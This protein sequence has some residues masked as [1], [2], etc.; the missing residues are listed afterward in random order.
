MSSPDSLDPSRSPIPNIALVLRAGAAGGVVDLVYATGRGLADSGSVT[1]PWRGVASG[2]LGGK[3]YDGNLSPV[4]LGLLTH[5]AIAM[6][7]AAV[8]V[9]GLNRLEPVQ[10]R[11]TAAAVVYGL[12]LYVVMYLVVLP[13]RWPAYFPT[14]D[15]V[16]SALDILAHVAVALVIAWVGGR[17]RAPE[18]A[19][20]LIK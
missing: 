8:W 19:L 18:V 3:A 4:V 12:G 15:G 13:L 20:R 9:W 7:M 6:V 16:R 1:T 17:P 10:R 2:W 5:F 14:W 11:R